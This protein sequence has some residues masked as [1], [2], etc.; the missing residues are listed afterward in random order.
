MTDLSH[1]RAQVTDLGKRA[2]EAEND[3]KYEEAYYFYMQAL[4]I[5]MQLLKYEKNPAL[6]KVYREK[7]GQYMSR[8]E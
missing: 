1:Y 5:F 7:M 8:A 2:T 3:K 6:T 4:E